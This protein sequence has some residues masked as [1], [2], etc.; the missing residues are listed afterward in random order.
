MY[1]GS[2]PTGE[3]V[4]GDFDAFV[5]GPPNQPRRGNP[6]FIKKNLEAIAEQMGHP[7][8]L[9]EGMFDKNLVIVRAKN[10]TTGERKLMSEA[11]LS[12]QGD[13]AWGREPGGT[14]RRRASC[15]S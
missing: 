9:V 12:A 4:L 6:D 3:A 2:D 11:E 7:K 13:K 15:S 10:D 1:K 5:G 8:I 14:I